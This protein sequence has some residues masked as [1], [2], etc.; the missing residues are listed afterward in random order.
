MVDRHAHDGVCSRAEQTP[1]NAGAYKTPLQVV[2]TL[3][4][5][6]CIVMSVLLPLSLN[7]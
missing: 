7:A 5:R 1:L 3:M 6:S 4:A 2:A